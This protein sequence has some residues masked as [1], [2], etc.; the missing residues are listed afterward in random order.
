MQTAFKRVPAVDKC[1][2]IL[3]LFAQSRHPLGI[4]EIATR[5]HLNKSTVFNIVR[6][7]RDLNVL[8]NVN[9]KFTFGPRLY[10]LG[11]AA[12]RGSEL[13]Q[14]VHPFLE[15]INHK[16]K[17]SAFLGIRSDTHALIIDK[18]DT[19][20]DIKLSSDIGMRLPLL[21]GAGGKALL[22]QLPDHKIDRILKQIKLKKFTPQT[23]VDKAEFKN[24]VLR[25]RNEGI[26]FDIEEYIEG[27]IAFALP[28]DTRRKTL[29]A[30]IW[31]V[32]LKRQCPSEEIPKLSEYLRSVAEDIN[33]R[34][35][36][37]IGPQLSK[38]A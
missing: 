18:V 4:S 19:A 20:Y 30:A 14:S 6:T 36:L 23:C 9:G 33:Q 7:L 32:G 5:L 15:Q 35:Y 2:T 21:A 13:I 12:G 17:L 24:Q 8:E 34:F 11:H 25:V 16:T 10:T 27:I 29:Q 3:E 31:A 26:A 28:L 22:A 37:N 38:S 1:F